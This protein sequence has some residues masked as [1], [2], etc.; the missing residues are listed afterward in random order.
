MA[1]SIA[2]YFTRSNL[3]DLRAIIARLGESLKD[4]VY[5]PN[6]ENYQ[7]IVGPYENWDQEIDDE[8]TVIERLLHGPIS[9]ALLI[10]LCRSVQN[11]A[12][13]TAR[14]VLRQLSFA[15]DGVVDDGIGCIAVISQA[16]K[17]S[18]LMAGYLHPSRSP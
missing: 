16:L 2:V 7:V 4:D 18:E 6:N 13:Q 17:G 10:E 14:D 5:V 9:C 12:C 15:E 3:S 8:W 1:E 11:Q